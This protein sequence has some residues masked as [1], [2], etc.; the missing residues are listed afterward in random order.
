VSVSTNDLKTGMTLQL[1]GELWQV[2]GFQHVKPGKGHAFVRTKLRNI[3]SGVVLDRT[4]RSD[5]KVGLA[6][7][8][9]REMQFLYRDGD[10]LVFMDQETYEQHH[11]PSVVVGDASRF[12]VE[13]ATA[14]I[15]IYE[16]TPIGVE[17]PAATVL[18]VTK[19]D[20]GVKGDRVSGAVKPAT[21]ETGI[22]VQV[23]LFVEEGER[24]KVD[25]RS[26]QYLE[27]VK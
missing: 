20:P 16:G 23:P 7:L 13:G 27:R 17:L 3:R 18:R 8:E 26:G 10:D 9:R 15:A 22:T 1:D 4:F 2:L 11:V 19:T 24:V 25:T 5:E 6:I 12:L 21:L 14:V